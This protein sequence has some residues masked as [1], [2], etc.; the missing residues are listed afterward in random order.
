MSAKH[1][2]KVAGVDGCKAGWLVAIVEVKGKGRSFELRDMPLPVK[3]FKEVLS[4][5][6]KSNCKIVCVDI[7]IGLRD[8]NGE[9]ECDKEARK[10]LK[11]RGCCV[12][13]SPIRRCLKAP[14]YRSACA[15]S[16]Q[17]TSPPKKLSK[18]TFNILQK[19]AD[20]DSHLSRS[21]NLQRRVREI[22]PEVSFCVLNGGKPIAHSKKKPAGRRKRIKLLV[23][24]FPN[25]KQI[26]KRKPKKVA[27]D[28]IL[29]ALV[30]AYTAAQVAVGNA[31]TLPQ[32]PL[33][34]N[35]DSKGLRMEIVYP[36]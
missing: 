23:S 14:D 1:T 2:F 12:F 9:R 11:H 21:H 7:P 5:K 20:V 17:H 34:N 26:L 30:A 16:Q 22:H 25:V 19:I 36:A 24:I 27:H 35:K 32:D 18:Q 33:P 3:S 15:I 13:R 31:A 4:I 29:D 8:G 6:K 28:D 10:M